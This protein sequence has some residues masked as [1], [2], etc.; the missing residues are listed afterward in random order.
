MSRMCLKHPRGSTT[1]ERPLDTPVN[2]TEYHHWH[3]FGT[4]TNHA[5]GRSL[6]GVN[7]TLSYV[8]HMVG[9]SS[10]VASE[11]YQRL[12]NLYA[13][14]PAETASGRIDIGYGHAELGGIL[15]GNSGGK[16]LNR[17][18]HHRL[19]TDASSLAASSVEKDGLL[20]LGQFNLS[21]SRPEYRGSVTAS[22]EVV[23]AEPPRYHVRAVLLDD[24]GDVLA[25]ALSFFEPSGEEL[26][27]DPAPEAGDQD[28]ATPAP[29]PFMPIHVTQYGV[30]CLN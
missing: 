24:E 15:E 17:A 21:V 14:S 22:A 23:V 5:D 25:E 2:W 16:L 11:H 18:P 12:R 7:R 20:T 3:S 4:Y 9:T 30:L 26:P 13:A 8:S 6:G 1:W 28:D 19:L 27:P 10:M 29:A